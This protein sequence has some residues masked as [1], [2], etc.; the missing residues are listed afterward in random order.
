MGLEEAVLRGR[1]AR[2]YLGRMATGEPVSCKGKESG[3]QWADLAPW[4][5][6]QQGLAASGASSGPLD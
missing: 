1:Q 5:E 2:C 3:Q 6:L 4:A